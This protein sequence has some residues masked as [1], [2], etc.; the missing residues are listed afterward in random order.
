MAWQDDLLDISHWALKSV[1]LRHRYLNA[2]APG[3][4][5]CF[6]GVDECVETVVALTI[7]EAARGKSYISDTIECEKRY[8]SVGGGNPQ[9]ADLA[10]K[11]PGVGQN[12]A[13]IEVK[14][15]DANGKAKIASD[16]RKLKSIGKRVQRWVLTYRVRPVEGRA[17]P[18]PN[19]LKKNFDKE[20]E[21][22]GSREFRTFTSDRDPG[23][24]DICLA[25]VKYSS[26]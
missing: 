24:C 19:I 22:H 6:P 11:E 1:D 16:I 3:D 18:L 12:W 15:Y 26:Q 5:S 23:V 10:F 14:K 7:Y 21:V 20:L 4:L 25:K 13:Y 2:K 8:P 9:R 17:K